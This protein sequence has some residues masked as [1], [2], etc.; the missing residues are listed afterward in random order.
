MERRILVHLGHGG[1]DGAVG[2]LWLRMRS[3][4]T[5]A[6]FQYTPDWLRH[7]GRFGL[8]PAL[9]LRAG[10]FHAEGGFGC[11]RDAAPDRWGRQL[12]GLA[13]A[14]AAAAGQTPGRMAETDVLLGVADRTRHGALRF[15]EE[16]GGPF[17]GAPGPSR[18]G[19][20]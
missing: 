8:D 18:A 7:P 17:L 3:G 20:R 13:R 6:S 2:Q 16:P 4:R 14:R 12:I 19:R 10:P 1:F 9:D 15:R 11:F 5:T